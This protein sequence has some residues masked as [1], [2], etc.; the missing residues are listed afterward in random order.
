ML[1]PNKNEQLKI[2]L[3]PGGE[4][5][6]TSLSFDQSYDER[7][8]MC[9]FS[10]HNQMYLIGGNDGLSRVFKLFVTGEVHLRNEK[11][12]QKKI[13]ERRQLLVT[14][15]GIEVLEQLP[16]RFND[17]RCLNYDD[18]HVL[19]CAGDF[20]YQKECFK[21]DGY[22]YTRMSLT[23]FD[24][25]RGGMARWRRSGINQ[26][27]LQKNYRKTKQKEIDFVHSQDK[28]KHL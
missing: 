21:F 11:Y 20:G 7:H 12:P 26:V 5:T 1:N 3:K 10:L 22:N 9:S 23:V 15:S 18:Q 8:W 14:E 19:A 28:A 16:F 24:H 25:Y 17:G 2:D 13:N 6:V 27:Y 4:E